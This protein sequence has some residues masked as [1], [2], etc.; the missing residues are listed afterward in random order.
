MSS[1]DPY[2]KWLGISPRDQPPNHYRL[3]GIELFESDPDVIANAADQ[4]MSHV[5]SFQTG[6]NSDVSQRILNEVA[7]ARVCLLNA[8]KKADYDRQLRAILTL[9]S[10]SV[11]EPEDSSPLGET[12][13]IADL[14][15]VPTRTKQTKQPTS[16]MPWV[17]VGFGGLVA[18][19]VFMLVTKGDRGEQVVGTVP[20]VIAKVASKPSLRSVAND[21]SKSVPQPDSKVED[22]RDIVASN[23]RSSK[24]DLTALRPAIRIPSIG[25]KIEADAASQFTPVNSKA[26]TLEDLVSGQAGETGKMNVTA[27]PEVT[28][29]VSPDLKNESASAN[30]EFIGPKKRSVPD[31]IATKQMPAKGTDNAAVAKKRKTKENS[32]DPLQITTAMLKKKLH[33]KVAY[34]PKTGE[35]VLTYDW[36]SR[37]QLDDFD[38]TRAKPT[39]MRGVLVLRAGD[40]MRH[41]VDFQEVIIAVPVVV[42]S[43]RG[44]I[45]RTSGGASASV[46]GANPDTMYLGGGAGASALIVPDSQRKGIQYIRLTLE[47]TRLVFQYGHGNNPSQ[48]ANA[49]TDFHAGQVELFGGDV[50]F[51]YGMLVLIGTIDKHWAIQFL[52]QPDAKK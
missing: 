22:S 31:S 5:K 29:E 51:Q 49:V 20:A 52:S 48:L 36:A 33:G 11:A 40:S 38:L 32:P 47:R 27:K 37:K 30:K 4:R 50:G 10:P 25:D 39:L 42:P 28:P 44:M 45:I 24:P 8:Q 2:H 15:F 21:G 46:G 9:K 1:F 7:A 13:S 14:G 41:V 43:M 12:S 35:L 26:A 16:W 17:F 19:M 3:L 34:N 18:T 23:T 6:K